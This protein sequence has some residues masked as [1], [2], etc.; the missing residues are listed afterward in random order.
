MAAREGILDR[1]AY[2]GAK[3]VGLDAPDVDGAEEKGSVP[4]PVAA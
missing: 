2:N 4:A 1:D 3:G